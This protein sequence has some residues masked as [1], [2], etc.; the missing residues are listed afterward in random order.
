[1]CLVSQTRKTTQEDHHFIKIQR[2]FN[3]MAIILMI[4]LSVG[5]VKS[6]WGFSRL[7]RTIASA[8]KASDP[9]KG[10]PYCLAHR[11]YIHLCPRRLTDTFLG[12]PKMGQYPD[13]ALRLRHRRAEPMARIM[14]GSAPD[15][16][17]QATTARTASTRLVMPRLPSPQPRGLLEE[18]GPAF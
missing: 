1:M 16:F 17:R 13:F 15:F 12:D 14:N 7:M 18:Y 3:P 11:T 6:V 10:D 8:S 2:V 5:P 9:G 4:P